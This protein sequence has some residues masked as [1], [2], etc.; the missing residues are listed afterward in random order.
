M[1]A[2]VL[3]RTGHSSQ[4]RLALLV[5][6]REFGLAEVGPNWVTLRDPETLETG[7]ATIKMTVD[8]SVTTM[9]VTLHGTIDGD[10]RHIAITRSV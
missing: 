7:P 9:P 8:G 1:S 10:C 3:T 4:V 2:P 6:G 5:D